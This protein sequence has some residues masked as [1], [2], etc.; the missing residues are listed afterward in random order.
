MFWLTI[1]SEFSV[2][3]KLIII[4]LTKNLIIWGQSNYMQISYCHGSIDDLKVNLK[5]VK[6]YML[7]INIYTIEKNK[8]NKIIL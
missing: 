6:N 4:L 8:Y 1:L 5:Y 7:K 2:Q 3:L